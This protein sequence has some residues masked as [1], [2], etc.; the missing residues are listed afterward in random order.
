MSHERYN[1]YKTKYDHL[2]VT[3]LK[4]NFLFCVCGGGEWT[5]QLQGCSP[6][7]LGKEV[8]VM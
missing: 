7:D 2:G 4:F 6:E 1:G 3:E 5:L 8:S